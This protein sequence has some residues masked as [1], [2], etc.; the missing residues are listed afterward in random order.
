M[1]PI[2]EGPVDIELNPTEAT[3]SWMDGEAT[4]AATL[5]IAEFKRY[6]SEGAIRLNG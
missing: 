6:V 3:L 4:G 1:M 5:P 2:P